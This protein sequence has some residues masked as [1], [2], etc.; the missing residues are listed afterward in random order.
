MYSVPDG[1]GHRTVAEP[2]LLKALALSVCLLPYVIRSAD[3]KSCG[4]SGM[5]LHLKLQKILSILALDFD[6]SCKNES[7]LDDEVAN[8]LSACSNTSIFKSV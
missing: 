6:S 7:S 4:Y 5:Q 1:T 2:S 8:N 3:D